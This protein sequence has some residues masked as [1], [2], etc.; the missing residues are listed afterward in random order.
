MK[1]FDGPVG[2]DIN[3]QK[4][5]VLMVLDD[6]VGKAVTRDTAGE[7]FFR[8]FIVEDRTTQ[9][10]SCNFRFRYAKGDS[11]YSIG[12]RPHASRAERVADLEE[13]MRFV[14]RTALGSLI[15]AVADS[16]VPDNIIASYFP[17]DDEG[18]GMNTVAWLMEKDLMRVREDI[19]EA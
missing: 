11:W 7:A 18:D 5:L 13:G 19:G 1:E 3:N 10:I 4:L 17:P 15:E 16:E 9:E 2:W 8:A 6:E 12:P 14:L